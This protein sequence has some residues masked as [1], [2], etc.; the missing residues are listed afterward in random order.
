M[1][2]HFGN[3]HSFMGLWHFDIPTLEEN[4]QILTPYYHLVTSRLL[5]RPIDH[6]FK[7]IFYLTTINTKVLS[8]LGVRYLISDKQVEMTDLKQRLKIASKIDP[9]YSLYLYELSDPNDASYS[10]STF[11]KL[12]DLNK[13][14]SLMGSSDINFREKALISSDWRQIPSTSEEIDFEKADWSPLVKSE[15]QFH[16]GHLVLSAQ[17]KS[18]SSV[19]LPIQYTHCLE[20]DVESESP[21]YVNRANLVET[22]IVFK[23]RVVAKLKNNL[24]HKPFQDCRAKDLEDIKLHSFDSVEKKKISPAFYPLYR[25]P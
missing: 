10:P 16:R 9:S 25:G 7:N 17:S 18:W 8:M 1:V 20:F 23:K 24:K 2:R 19:L 6:L 22:V 15:L 21:I 11:I 13:I 5:G 4:S 12:K 14:I 3:I